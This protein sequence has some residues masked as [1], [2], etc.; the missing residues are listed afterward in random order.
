VG[1]DDGELAA[2]LLAQ[3]QDG[4]K[5]CFE[6]PDVALVPK[7]PFE[8]IVKLWGVKFFFHKSSLMPFTPVKGADVCFCFTGNDKKLLGRENFPPDGPWR[9]FW[10]KIL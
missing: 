3:A 10:R 9:R 8:H 4:H 1:V 7:D 5:K 6:D 2:L